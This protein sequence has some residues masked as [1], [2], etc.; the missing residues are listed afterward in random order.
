VFLLI[1]VAIYLPAYCSMRVYDN[2]QI[3][4]NTVSIYH[5]N[6]LI[7]SRANV[8]APHDYVVVG[9]IAAL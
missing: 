3:D 8:A 7:V 9:A 2:R 5:N 1:I 4:G 6:E